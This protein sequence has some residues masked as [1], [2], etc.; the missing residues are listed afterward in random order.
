MEVL[1]DCTLFL[2]YSCNAP[3]K[4]TNCFLFAKWFSSERSWVK[5]VIRQLHP[6]TLADITSQ[7]LWLTLSHKVCPFESFQSVVLSTGWLADLK[8][9]LVART[10]GAVSAQPEGPHGPR[11]LGPLR[12]ERPA[13]DLWRGGFVESSVWLAWEFSDPHSLSRVWLFLE[14][15]RNTNVSQQPKR[16]A[17][18]IK[19]NPNKWLCLT[20][21]ASSGLQKELQRCRIRR[22]RLTCPLLKCLCLKS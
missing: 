7:R 1:F 21:I 6:P 10:A 17:S 16:K 19:C 18:T 14:L 2:S 20:F 9:W 11:Q 15:A 8:R 5:R 3:L 12:T 22:T 13:G 4:L